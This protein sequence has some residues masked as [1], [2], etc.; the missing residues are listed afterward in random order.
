M[1]F[2]DLETT[3]KK[4]SR[5]IA[6]Y[7]ASGLQ[8]DME[9]QL[10]FAANV[11]MFLNTTTLVEHGIDPMGL[12]RQMDQILVENI[13]NNLSQKVKAAV[14]KKL[15]LP[16]QSTVDAMLAAYDFT[17]IRTTSEEGMSTEERTIISEIKKALRSLISGGAFSNLGA[18]GGK[19]RVPEDVAFSATRIQTGPESRGNKDTPAGSVPLE[20]FEEVVAAAYQ[21]AIVDFE[22]GNGNT[23]ALDFSIEPGINE[24]GQAV[25]LTG[26][27]ELARQEA[28]HILERNRAKAVPTM[29]IQI[30]V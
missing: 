6:A 21:N 2:T 17:G 12:A 1:N 28:A 8:P 23:A 30:G 27:I 9:I 22:D 24:H 18:D 25:N 26:V 11:D 7:E 10:P 15:P 4:F 5:Q 3:T 19:T 29:D 14:S 16:D 20:N 13:G